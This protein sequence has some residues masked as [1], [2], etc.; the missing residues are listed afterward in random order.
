MSFSQ[1]MQ[2]LLRLRQSLE[3]QEEMKLSLANAKLQKARRGLAEEQQ[4]SRA[5]QAALLERL[6]GAEAAAPVSAAELQVAHL[7]REAERSRE[8]HLET[9]VQQL[10][11]AHKEQAQAL[12]VRTRERKTLD[13]LRAQH[14][15]E[16]RREQLRRD[17][18]AADEAFLLRP[19]QK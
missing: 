19:P 2:R 17:Q 14:L 18:A 12:G 1:S 10:S 11:A 4:N 8:R 9:A 15:E 7:Q 3:R 16:Q 6:H 13:A 5:E